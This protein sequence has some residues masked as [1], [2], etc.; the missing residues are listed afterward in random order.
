MPIGSYLISEA[1][2]Y[3]PLRSLDEV[4]A[5]MKDD[6]INWI[7]K[8]ITQGKLIQAIF[9]WEGPPLPD[10]ADPMP[11]PIDPFY[12]TDSQGRKTGFEYGS[13]HSE[14][15]GAEVMVY[16]GMY[17]FTLPDDDTYTLYTAGNSYYTGT[18]SLAVPVGT[19]SLQETVYPPINPSYGV[20]ITMTFDQTTTDWGLH[21]DGQPD[22]QPSLNQLLQTLPA[23]YV[24]FVQ[25]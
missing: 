16:D 21:I 25:R 23:I 9:S 24:P 11:L 5:K 7:R 13:Y 22:V 17:Y 15:P 8:D 19:T 1:Y 3:D 2:A 10:Y 18:L 14:I 6:F 4:T 20:S 12:F